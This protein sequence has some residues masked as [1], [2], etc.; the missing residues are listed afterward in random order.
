[1]DSGLASLIRCLP[2][3]YA[4]DYQMRVREFMNLKHCEDISVMDNVF[5]KFNCIFLQIA[6]DQWD[7][8]K[9][10]SKVNYSGKFLDCLPDRYKVRY[11]NIANSKKA[12]AAVFNS[13]NHSINKTNS[14]TATCAKCRRSVDQSAKFCSHCGTAVQRNFNNNQNQ[15]PRSNV[16][17]PQQRQRGQ[18][19]NQNSQYINRSAQQNQNSKYIN[20]SAQQNQNSKYI[21]RSAQQ[22]QNS[23]YVNRSAQQYQQ[24]SRSN[25]YNP[26]QRR[27]G[28]GQ[29]FNQNSKYI[30]RSAQQRQQRKVFSQQ[31]QQNRSH[32]AVNAKRHQKL[33]G[34]NYN[35]FNSKAKK[36]NQTSK[37]YG[38]KMDMEGAFQNDL[39]RQTQEQHI[40]HMK[41]RD[42]YRGNFDLAMRVSRQSR[43]QC[44]Q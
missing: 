35:K 14:S 22:P 33:L 38:N 37:R 40:N 34:S 2:S 7:R 28:G 9:T 19:H 1:M 20:R 42:S 10:I 8:E 26:Q 32:Q 16:Y 41:G 27:Q 4:E 15:Q 44:G 39:E 31:P 24:Q 30:N 21:N 17:N 5:L 43:Q 12:Q 6:K 18:T 13:N 23:K 29:T 36:N 3:N 11:R 25:V